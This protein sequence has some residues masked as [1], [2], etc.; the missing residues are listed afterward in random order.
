MVWLL[1]V[2][3]IG[4]IEGI[5]DR[6]SAPMVVFK[7]FHSLLQLQILIAENDGRSTNLLK[8]PGTLIPHVY[9]VQEKEDV[10][11]AIKIFYFCKDVIYID[12][13]NG[14]VRQ[15]EE[16]AV[17]ADGFRAVEENVRKFYAL[18]V[19]NERKSGCGYRDKQVAA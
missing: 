15:S 14:R 16:L 7:V 8:V 13:A 11:A 10:K 3:L 4:D 12:T 5:C 1:S 19:L 2:I 6:V 9:I 18:C 17:D